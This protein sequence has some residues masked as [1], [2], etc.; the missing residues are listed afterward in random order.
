MSPIA[1]RNVAAVVTFT[2]GMVISLRTSG[3][4]TTSEAKA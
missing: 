1:E 4:S 2:P 3:E